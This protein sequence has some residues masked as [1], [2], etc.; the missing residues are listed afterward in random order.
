[1]NFSPDRNKKIENIQISS[2]ETA[3]GSIYQYLPD[4][5]T[6]RF[7]KVENKEYEPQDVI[8]FIP[9]WDTVLKKAPKEFIEKFENQTEYD[10][11]LLKY[12]QKEKI[13][14]INEKGEK[15][16]DNNHKNSSQ[17]IF[18]ALNKKGK[19]SPDYIIPVSK[20]PI[21]NYKPYDTRKYFNE[22]EKVFER[23]Q[24]IGNRIV[25]INYH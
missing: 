16:K 6:Q 11:L 18:I 13:Y 23:D 24:H 9:D 21:I 8:V 14:P 19:E 17:E 10:Q 1:M 3:K 12:A 20:T 4:G 2:I 22:D 5:R 7:K 15:L 25:N